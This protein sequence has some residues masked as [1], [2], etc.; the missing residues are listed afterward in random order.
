MTNAYWPTPAPDSLG[1]ILGADDV[2]DAVKATIL[3]WSPYYLRALSS[4]LFDAGRIGKTVSGVKQPPYPLPP[5]GVW[6]NEPRFRN[7]G[8]GEPPA[9]LVTVPA[10]VGTP[11]L[12][13]DRSYTASWRVQV[14]VR[15]FGTSWEEAVDLVSWYEKVVRW[16]VIQHRSLGGLAM[17]TKWAGT[18]YTGEEHTSTRTEG[19][20][21]LGFDVQ[22]ADVVEVRGPSVVPDDLPGQDPSVETVLFALDLL[23]PLPVP[24][25][26]TSGIDGGNAR[27]VADGYLDGGSATTTSDKDIDGGNA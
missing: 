14:T 26:S 23:D 1:N 7:V 20:A 27:S 3:T 22:L 17:S 18:Q 6:V 10:T 16:S 11:D 5:F 2:R 15:V 4:R 12:H 13:G 24:P 21:V 25:P 9:F 19:Q 8:T